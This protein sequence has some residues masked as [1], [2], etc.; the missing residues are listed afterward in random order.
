MK[1][2]LIIDDNK[3]DLISYTAIFNDASLKY[4]ALPTEEGHK[5]YNLAITENPDVIIID[6][7]LADI[8]GFEICKKLKLNESTRHIP[9][10]MI[11]AWGSNKDYRLKSLNAGAETFLSKP[12]KIHEILAQVK[13]L[14]RI[15]NSE[16]NLKKERDKY[17]KL[18]QNKTEKLNEL[19]SYLNLQIRTMPIGL[20]TLDADFKIKTWNPAA[21][22]IFGFS[23]K[24]S[25]GKQPEEFIISKET[26]KITNKIKKELYKGSKST[27]SINENIT[28]SG[29]TIVCEW[30]NTPLVD[31]N[32]KIIGFLSM[33]KDITE[34][35]YQRKLEK[36]IT[37]LNESLLSETGEGFLNQFTL[38]ITK[39]LESDVTFIGLLD[40]DQKGIGTTSTCKK[41]EIISNFNYPLLDSPCED[42]IKKEI[43]SYPSKVATLF[44]NAKILQK[45]KAEGYIGVP[46]INTKGRVLG[47]IVAIFQKPIP[48]AIFDLSIIQ[49]FT[50]RAAAEIE[51][52]RYEQ[53]ISK[54][55]SEFRR[56]VDE[57]PYPIT[58]TENNANVYLNKKFTSTFGYTLEDIPTTKEWMNKA[59]P[60]KKYRDLAT[61]S[62]H[63]NIEA[64]HNINDEV[65]AQEWQLTAKDGTTKTCEY[66]MVLSGNTSLVV[67]NDISKR[68]RAE[69][70][71]N[72][73]YQIS[74][75]ANTTKELSTFIHV[76]KESLGTVLDTTN[77]F[78]AFYD[79]KKDSLYA[80]YEADEKDKIE[81]W[82]AKKCLTGL[83][84]KRNQPLFVTKK[85]I[86]GMIDS[87][88][89]NAIGSVAESWVGVPLTIDGTVL[90]AFVVQ[91]YTNP[92]AYNKKDVKLLEFISHQI[93][94][95]IQRIKNELDLGNALEKAIESD[96]LKSVFLSTMSHE[97]RTPL[98]AIIGFSDL[99]DRNTKPKDLER[100]VKTINNSGVLL[101]ELVEGLFDITLIEAGEVQVEKNFNN[102]YEIL[103]DLMEVT[104]A[105]QLKLDKKAITIKVNDYPF[106]KDLEIFTDKHKLKQVL[107]NLLKN[108]LKFTHTGSIN[109]DVSKKVINKKS[110][111]KFVVKDTG[112]GIPSEKLNLIFDIFR[113]ADDS[114]TRKYGGAGIGL[115]V[116]QKLT[117][118][119]G[120]SIHV[121]SVLNKGTVF[122]V[123]IPLT[124]NKIN[125]P[126][127]ASEDVSLEM[128]YPQK[129]ILVAEDDASSLVLLKVYL[130]KLGVNI[131]HAKNGKEA[132]DLF[133]NNGHQIDLILM[134][135]NMPI[136]NGYDAS[137]KIKAHNPTVPIIAQTA[138]A[139]SGDRE[140][141]LE[142]G[143]DDYISKPINGKN[144]VSLIKKFL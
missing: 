5:G 116:T 120:G 115:S 76:I 126:K 66:N 4:K 18:A 29:K 9:I 57:F 133:I 134:D 68:K 74:N 79:E 67:L 93:S 118:L 34:Q 71:Q 35:Y 98:N 60:D 12:I 63:K 25:I 140:K 51:R 24:D 73:L 114:H 23:A 77:F 47:L 20:I 136:M 143:C 56:T 49:V 112:I 95:S 105:E 117:S 96:R 28:K 10:I 65:T 139:I 46:L 26:I 87:G 58:I 129:T 80:P 84:I 97:L 16:N 75:A 110:F 21:T 72:I 27:Q 125:L 104:R 131:L 81:S 138:Y 82:P 137:M 89:I 109:L 85:E 53:A 33:V 42:V 37:S 122:T 1:K 107:L 44:P 40:D 100:F 48:E 121:E 43:C 30:T 3:N 99:I 128:K 50:A 17:E 41:G 69:L 88:E 141:A 94:T 83:V 32:E 36:A 119:L 103:E 123:L 62:W 11:S 6:V 64:T 130:D 111:I 70:I 86:L 2:I 92:D 52:T 106:S 78:V 8:N 108:A 127:N 38:Q 7:H 55:E 13:V 124:E 102:L 14:I 101:L 135:I 113:Q 22:Q 39:I 91:N 61:A 19:N 142:N 144:L 15:K 54:S 45:Y 59:Y 90:G 31:D 132:V